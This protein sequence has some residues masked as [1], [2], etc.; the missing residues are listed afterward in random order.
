MKLL[1]NILSV[2]TFNVH[3]DKERGFMKYLIYIILLTISFSVKADDKWKLVGGSGK[4][5]FVLI[6]KAQEKNTDVYRLAIGDVC[7]GK[8]WCKVLFWTNPKMIPKHLPMSDKQLKALKADWVYNGYNSGFKQL[9]WSCSIV[10][11]PDQC[12]TY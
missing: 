11:D 4:I 8:S 10:N 6:D 2:V 5:Q 3:A 9:L 1:F 12:F 7:M